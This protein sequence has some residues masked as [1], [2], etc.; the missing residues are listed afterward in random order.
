MPNLTAQSPPQ[1]LGVSVQVTKGRNQLQQRVGTFQALYEAT[2]ARISSDYLELAPGQ[3]YISNSNENIAELVISAT[4]G[5]LSLAITKTV[6]TAPQI[7]DFTVN[8]LFV[9]DDTLTS[10]VLSNNGTNTVRIDLNYTSNP[11]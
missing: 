7:S 3:S 5:P 6:N 9:I 1:S 8:R 11:T 10:F 4:G 2:N